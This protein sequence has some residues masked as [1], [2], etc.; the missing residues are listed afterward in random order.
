MGLILKGKVVGGGIKSFQLEDKTT[1]YQNVVQVQTEKPDGFVD[2]ID[3]Y[4][5]NLERRFE[6]GKE[7]ELP[8][9]ISAYVS[10][11]GSAV[12]QYHT[13][14]GAVSSVPITKGVKV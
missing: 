14:N 11:K 7:I 4:E 5:K 6:V 13:E 2:V 12:T 9:W 10:K 3:V 8:V 1:K